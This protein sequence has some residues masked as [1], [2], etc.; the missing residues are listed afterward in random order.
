MRGIDATVE[1]Q[2]ANVTSTGG[3]SHETN[4]HNA[5]LMTPKETCDITASDKTED[6][7]LAVVSS[8]PSSFSLRAVQPVCVRIRNLGVTVDTSSSAFSLASLLP[9]RKAQSHD[10][11]STAA[12]Q[13]KVILKDV[14]ADMPPGSL[15]AI[16]GGS[17]SGKTS[18]L[19]LLASRMV[20]S[21]LTRSGT[22][23]FNGSPSV[24]GVRSAYVMQQDILLPTLTVR[25][26]LRY[27]AALRLPPPTTKDEREK[28]V[29]E[30]ILEL[31]L[32]QCA[33]TRVGN[34]E[35]K[36][37]SGGEKRRVSIGVQL[38][39]NPSVLFLDEP[40]TG[41]DATSAFQLVRTL[42]GLAKKGRT[43]ITTIHQPR[44]EIWGL[45]DSLII[46]TRG[47]PVYSGDAAMAL[48]WFESLGFRLP[49]FV[50]PA[51]FLIDVAAVDNRSAQL[52]RESEQRVGQLKDAWLKDGCT[53]FS[54]DVFV[55]KAGTVDSS[56]R[57]DGKNI[58]QVLTH[59]RN[60][61]GRQVQVLTARTWLVTTRDPLGMTGSIVEAIFLGIITGWVFLSL[62]MDQSGIRSREGALYTA[63]ALQGYLILI[64]ETYRLTIDIELFD[65]ENGE[66]VVDVVPFLL[67]RRLARL[68]VEDIPVPLLYSLIF[69]WMA[70][71]RAGEYHPGCRSTE[72]L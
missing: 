23:D 1:Q 33:D 2:G 53:R 50:N 38:L 20:S 62:G 60:A 6:S 9:R 12:P 66:G 41:L 24:H 46:L 3:P 25:E 10:P 34:H 28:I 67:S 69:Y 37:C 31:G 14:S 29:E 40:T 64:F 26:T 17:G 35:H 51:E 49:A 21:R 71:F 54:Q 19:N 72:L 4:G 15:T 18:C 32:K 52:E 63:A 48:P 22:T 27:S 68:L 5:P 16:L 59:H 57:G 43:I 13:T 30:I 8:A 61:F 45:F 65:R 47:S 42:K 70:G 39:S 36:G 44:S 55:E 58:K 56:E 7:S 11:E